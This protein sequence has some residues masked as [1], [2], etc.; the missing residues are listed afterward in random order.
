MTRLTFLTLPP[1]P[2][3]IKVRLALKLKGLDFE[4]IEVGFEDRKEVIKRSGQPL[5]PVL[6]DGDRTVYDSFGI[7]RYLD[8]NWPEPKL[9]NE[10]RE[11]QREIQDWEAYSREVGAALGLVAGQAFSGEVDDAKTKQSEELYLTLPERTEA[12]LANQDYLMGDKPN[13]ADL[14]VMPFFQLAIAMPDSVPEGLLRFV[15]ERVNLDGKFPLT[16]AW[17]ERVLALDAAVV[18]S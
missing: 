16:R 6:V 9:F 13:A 12:A 8:A 1:S 11:G 18:S 17:A 14:S 3:N 15:A 2:Y 10:T 7:L 5:T 4:T